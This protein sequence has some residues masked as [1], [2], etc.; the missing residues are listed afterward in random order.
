MDL[1][2]WIVLAIFIA[3]M[4]FSIGSRSQPDGNGSNDLRPPG[5]PG[6]TDPLQG[7]YDV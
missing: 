2:P 5:E 1:G 7:R 6:D 4:A 3:L